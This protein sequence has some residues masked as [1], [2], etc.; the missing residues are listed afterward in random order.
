MTHAHTRTR[1]LK[2]TLTHHTR[3]RARRAPQVAYRAFERVDDLNASAAEVQLLLNLSAEIPDTSPRLRAGNA[4][5]DEEA[6]AATLL[7]DTL[8][9]DSAYGGVNGTSA[10]LRAGKPPRARSSH[11]LTAVGGRLVLYG[12]EAAATIEHELG[13]VFDVAG[14]GYSE[15]TLTRRDPGGGTY[16]A[17]A[18]LDPLTSVAMSQ[19]ASGGV[20]PSV[21]VVTTGATS[22]VGDVPV[23][24]AT[25]SVER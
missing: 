18:N 16:S 21:P 22:Q 17:P 3:A 4:P 7:T 9:D 8:G 14:L 5:D 6:A 13:D 10:G 19:T 15:G 12:G 25:P 2:L 24:E 20:Q 1:T 11:T 23:W